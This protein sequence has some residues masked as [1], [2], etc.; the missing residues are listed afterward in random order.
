MI[1]GSTRPSLGDV[2]C[3]SAP[4][5]TAITGCGLTLRDG[6][7]DVLAGFFDEKNAALASRR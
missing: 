7:V 2:S 6:V 4:A 5:S 1:A 3:A